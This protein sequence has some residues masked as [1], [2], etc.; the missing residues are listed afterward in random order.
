MNKLLITAIAIGIGAVGAI[1]QHREGGGR[2]GGVGGGHI[3]AHGPVANRAPMRENESRDTKENR[4]AV[5]QKGHPN[6]PHVHAKNDEWVGH[7]SGANDPHYHLD[8]PW[9][10]GRFSGGFGP[11]HV[12]VLTGGNRNRFWFNN[13]YWAVAPFDYSI[14]DDW[15]WAGDQIVIYEDPV[16]VGWYLGYNSRLG[17]Y[18]HIEYLGL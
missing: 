1:G 14:V 9:A 12:F 18:A 8:H 5:D 2:E 3:P 16:H 11:Q 7:R 10:H 13:F 4:I 6:L 15:N 17:T